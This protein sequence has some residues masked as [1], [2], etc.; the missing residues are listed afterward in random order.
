[1]SGSMRTKTHMGPGKVSGQGYLPGLTR[2]G[3][4]G[5]AASDAKESAWRVILR[6]P[7]SGGLRQ[8]NAVLGVTHGERKN[9]GSDGSGIL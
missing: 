5:R 9:D 1:M 8:K 3:E 2:Q 4:G 6:N 7:W